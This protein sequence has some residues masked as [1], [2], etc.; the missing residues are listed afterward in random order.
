MDAPTDAIER[1]TTADRPVD[2]EA[3]FHAQYGRIAGTI[4]RVIRDPGRAEELAVEV[5][6]KWSRHPEAQGDRAAGWLY[7]AAIRTALDELRRQGRR[8]RFERLIHFVSGGPSPEDLQVSRDDRDR[9]RG[10]LA[11]LPRR[12]AELLLLRHDGL[13]YEE[14]ASALELNPASVGT[15]LARAQRAFRREYMK[16]HGDA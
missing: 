9:V 8:A 12:Q 7:R 10:V 11:T 2:L 14:I 5:F 6:L 16:R 15:L 13:S 4:A 1:L 3:V